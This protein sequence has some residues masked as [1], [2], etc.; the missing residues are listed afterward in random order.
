MLSK[1]LLADKINASTLVWRE[2]QAKWT[3]LADVSE[4]QS[5][6][7]AIP[8]EL[9]KPTVSAQR[10]QLPKAGHWRRG[11]ARLIDLWMIGMPLG[12]ALGYIL[13]S[14]SLSFALWLQRPG[15]EYLFGWL[16][17]PLVMLIE[18]GIFALFGS[19]PGKALLGIKVMTPDGGRLTGGQYLRRQWGVYWFGAWTFF[20][21]ISL[22]GIAIQQRRL[23]AGRE[24]R[25]DEGHYE[26]RAAKLG[27]FRSIP[28]YV[29]VALLFSVNAVFHGIS[30]EDSIKLRTETTWQ[31][32]VTGLSVAVPKGWKQSTELNDEKQPLYFFTAPENGF[33]VIL[34]KEELPT[35]AS[36]EDYL[37]IW[38]D[39]VKED[40]AVIPTGQTVSNTAHESAIL[41]GYRT[42]DRSAKVSAVIVKKGGQ[43]WRLI[44][45]APSGKDPASAEPAR[46]QDALIRSI[47]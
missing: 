1:L 45:I 46:L 8:P 22:I 38:V 31:N 12:G 33:V 44:V 11:F 15:S 2:G 35:L 27:F 16:N 41:R 42:N 24:T 28:A 18:A 37:R 36:I 32:P 40:L 13:A 14:S 25:Y 17:M 5:V 30:R 9:P 26:V 3:P 34:A 21:L 29:V 7:R 43:F 47:G 20:P 6:L 23:I 10:T 4:L 19:T 39:V